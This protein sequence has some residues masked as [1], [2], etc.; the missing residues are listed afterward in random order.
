M[1]VYTIANPNLVIVDLPDL[2]FDLPVGAG[3]Q[4][5]GLVSAYRANRPAPRAHTQ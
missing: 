1:R 2:S 5:R 4:G 3:K